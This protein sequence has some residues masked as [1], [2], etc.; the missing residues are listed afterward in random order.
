MY[1]PQITVQ[2]YRYLVEC[3]YQ[4]TIKGWALVDHHNTVQGWHAAV[5]GD[6]Q[7]ATAESALKAFVPDTRAR[8]WR[9]R[10][11][12]TVQEDLDRYWLTAFLTAIRTGYTLEGG[13]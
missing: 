7:W 4:R 3:K 1:R 5:P 9:Q 2:E 12:W 11:G 13:G 6:S 8:Q 10:L